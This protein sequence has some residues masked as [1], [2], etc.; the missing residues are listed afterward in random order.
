MEFIT[1]SYSGRRIQIG[2]RSFAGGT[3]SIARYAVTCR[4]TLLLLAL[5]RFARNTNSPYA[6]SWQCL[7]VDSVPGDCLT[8]RSPSAKSSLQIN[9]S[10]DFGPPLRGASR[11]W[12]SVSGIISA[13]RRSH[14]KCGLPEACA[15]IKE[16]K[17]KKEESCTRKSRQLQ[18]LSAV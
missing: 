5:Q 17:S 16:L 11:G 9:S 10:S 4:R 1:R 13:I 14:Q 7:F 15:A 8:A 6:N 12:F 3:S 2:A 18:Y